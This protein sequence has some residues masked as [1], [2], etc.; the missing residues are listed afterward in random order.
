MVAV[1]GGQLH[2]L[3]DGD[4]PPIVLVHSAIV[5]MRAWDSI[6]PFLVDAGYRAIRYDTR[7][8]GTSPTEDVPF[9]NRADLVAVM[10]V[11]GTRQAAVV[12]NSRGAIIALDTVLE[13]PDR[14]AAFVWVGG[15]IN[16]FDGGMEPLEQE[17]EEA[18]EAAEEARDA[19]RMADLDLQLWVDGP[20]QSPTRVPAE[21]R[22]AVRAM[23]RP[24]VEPG[25]V[26]GKPIPLA[27]P[28]NGRLGEVRVPTLAVVG[29]L[30][31][32]GT[33]RSGARL[34]EGVAGA[35]LVEVPNVAHLVGMEAPAELADLI[36]RHLAPL[37]RWA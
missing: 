23:D 29:G 3:A 25:R 30:D 13:F 34:A 18:Y 8:F 10:D 35:R 20:G 24:I 12:G 27:P 5:D 28:A 31:T 16:G 9:S 1:P 33:R 22:E 2:A 32:S 4:G 15:G 11:V 7:G 26:F 37:P 21:L 14:F 36:V 6:V 19:D 17:L